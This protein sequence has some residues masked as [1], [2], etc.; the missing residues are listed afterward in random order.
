MKIMGLSVIFPLN[1]SIDKMIRIYS[2]KV[3]IASLLAH[4]FF[5]S[6]ISWFNHQLRD[7]TIK[8]ENFSSW[9]NGFLSNDHECQKGLL[10]G[11]VEVTNGCFTRKKANKLGLKTPR[12]MVICQCVYI[13]IYCIHLQLEQQF[14]V[15]YLRS[16][17]YPDTIKASNASEIWV[18]KLGTPK[19]ACGKHHHFP[20]GIS[21]YILYSDA[22]I[23]Y[24]LINFPI[25]TWWRTTH[26]S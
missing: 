22:S 18:W 21:M 19:K 20:M 11:A 10:G 26:E 24:I 2:S 3:R 14:Q 6:N 13:Y 5:S 12:S 17:L 15:R 7:V 16:S 25:P 9:S 23:C 8:H 4:Q 1:Q